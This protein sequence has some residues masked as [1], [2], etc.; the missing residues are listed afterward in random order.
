MRVTRA[1]ARAI[2]D[3]TTQAID[4]PLP[5]TPKREKRAPLGEISGNEQGEGVSTELLKDLADLLKSPNQK[6]T[7]KARGKNQ[8][9]HDKENIPEILEDD[10]VSVTSSAV[11]EACQVLLSPIKGKSM[12]NIYK[13][14]L[15]LSLCTAND[16]QRIDLQDRRGYPDILSSARV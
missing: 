3:E 16:V 5:S 13:A 2:E 7:K 12:A 8:T 10:D 9:R 14:G 6:S 1:T 15:Q 11:S 4:V